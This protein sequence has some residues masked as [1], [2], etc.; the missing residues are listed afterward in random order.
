MLPV[1]VYQKAIQKSRAD[2]TKKSDGY[3]STGDKY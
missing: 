1:G 2:G 3:E